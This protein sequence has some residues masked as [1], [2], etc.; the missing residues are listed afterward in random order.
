M[1]APLRPRAEL[2]LPWREASRWRRWKRL[3]PPLWTSSAFLGLLVCGL[4]W[5]LISLPQQLPL[6]AEL[7][8]RGLRFAMAAPQD[9]S[10]DSQG[11]LAVTL[12]G[13]TLSV[14]DRDPLT[15]SFAGERLQLASGDF[16]EMNGTDGE[17]LA[18]MMALPAH[19]T[20]VLQPRTEQELRQGKG[21]EH[22]VVDLVPPSNAPS[23]NLPTLTLTP[24]ALEPI[25]AQLTSQGHAV[26]ALPA[27]DAE[28]SLSLKGPIRLRLQL[29]DPRQVT[30]FEPNLQVEKVSFAGRRPSVFSQEPRP[31]SMLQ[32]GTVHLGRLEPLQLR[33]D[34]FLKMDPPGITEF[35]DL[36]REKGLYSVELVGQTRTLR[37][38]LSPHRPTI[39]VQGN[40]LRRHF[41]P[42]QIGGIYGVLT[43][44]AGSALLVL[45]KWERGNG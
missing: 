34:Q 6:E 30:V 29:T 24:P 44:A 41:T 21:V 37:A 31:Y 36:R 27:P 4:L 45:M 18:L 19:T 1:A 22:L 28:F 13:L 25:K 23:D 20:V 5:L 43:G 16:L 39:V 14:P 7:Q 40:L 38:G 12:K 35:T 3:L 8:S 9:S 26:R 32:G 42:E 15:L 33:P 10:Q 11:V 2:P 17:P